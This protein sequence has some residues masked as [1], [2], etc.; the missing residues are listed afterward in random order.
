M[1]RMFCKY[2]YLLFFRVIGQAANCIERSL[3]MKFSMESLKVPS[4][5]EDGMLLI[6]QTLFDIFN[7]LDSFQEFGNLFLVVVLSTRQNKT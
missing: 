5:N 3:G 2:F 1:C 4:L 6:S 7:F